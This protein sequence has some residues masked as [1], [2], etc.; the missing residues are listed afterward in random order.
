MIHV[1]VS[2]FTTMFTFSKNHGN[3]GCTVTKKERVQK[4][5]V[6]RLFSTNPGVH[7]RLN[8]STQFRPPKIHNSL[9]VCWIITRSKTCESFAPTQPQSRF[10]SIC[11]LPRPFTQSST[12]GERSHYITDLY[13]FRKHKLSF[14]PMFTET[15]AS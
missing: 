7:A 1:L 2:Q 4:Y 3:I 13:T 8:Y 5:T 15:P 12:K 14:S 9:T 6:Q 10:H 11:P